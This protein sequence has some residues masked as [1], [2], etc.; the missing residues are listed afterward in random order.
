MHEESEEIKFLDK[1]QNMEDSK[2]YYNRKRNRDKPEVTNLNRESKTGSKQG[3]TGSNGKRGRKKTKEV[4]CYDC[5]I[6]FFDDETF[7]SHDCYK[8]CEL[9]NQSVPM[10]LIHLHNCA[11]SS[12]GNSSNGN[13]SDNSNNSNNIDSCGISYDGCLSSESSS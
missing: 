2:T 7:Q 4:F 11:S 5:Q 13:N 8:Y 9:C 1:N 3:Q 6:T 12:N 10:K